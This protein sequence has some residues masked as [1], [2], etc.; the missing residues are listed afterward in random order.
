[1]KKKVKLFSTIASLCLAVALMA[2][3]VWAASSANFGVTSTVK[4]TLDGQIKATIEIKVEYDTAVNT[5]VIGA[6]TTYIDAEKTTTGRKAW[7]VVLL[8]GQEVPTLN[9]RDVINL[10]EY[11]F[12]ANSV[13]KVGSTKGTQI[14]YTITITNNAGKE[15]NKLK[16]TLSSRPTANENGAISVTESATN[17]SDTIDLTGTSVES[18]VDQ[19]RMFTYV[20]VYE[21]VDASKEE[22]TGLT[23]AP[24]FAMES[25]VA[26][27]GE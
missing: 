1:M 7:K 3:G 17:G 14:K 8:P 18:T 11:T 27:S 23:F 13:A 21:L 2:F 26:T 22:T 10:G 24:S 12:G 9:G 19:S 4:Y 16:V 25:V 5:N 20:V 6:N 15:N